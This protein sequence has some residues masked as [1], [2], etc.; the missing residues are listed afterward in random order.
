MIVSVCY[1]QAQKLNTLFLYG[2][3]TAKSSTES[4]RACS[5]IETASISVGAKFADSRGYLRETSS[6]RGY[7]HG[8]VDPLHFNWQG[9]QAIG[10]FISEILNNTTNVLFATISDQF[11]LTDTK[12]D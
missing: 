7:L 10:R 5:A 3:S 12:S 9:Y 1:K 2:L 11:K 8:P 4:K 6:I